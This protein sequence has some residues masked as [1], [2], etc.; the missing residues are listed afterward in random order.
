MASI[1][2]FVILSGFY[3]FQKKDF[4]IE[5]RHYH[6]YGNQR[7]DNY[8]DMSEVL[9]RKFY[10]GK[11][12]PAPERKNRSLQVACHIRR[13][14]V[15]SVNHPNRF[16]PNLHIEKQLARL[17]AFFTDLGIPYDIK[18]GSQGGIEEFEGLSKYGK[19]MLDRTAFEDFQDMVQADALITAKSCF[20]YCAALL[21]EGLMIYEP[22]Y[23][24]PLSNWFICTE[25]LVDDQ[26][27][28]TSIKK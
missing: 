12:L 18:I 10:A 6:E 14:D 26:R 1:L 7:Q 5:K 28:I 21:L 16:T 3:S 11:S 23:H 15:N 19:I 22:F 17:A 24:K 8:A 9:R 25:Q 13:G 27:F 20:S 4:L 2:K